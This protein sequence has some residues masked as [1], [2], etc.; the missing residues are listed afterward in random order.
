M[1]A[2]PILRTESAVEFAYVG[3]QDHTYRIP[4]G[5]ELEP[6]RYRVYSRWLR[7]GADDPPA[8]TVAP[9]TSSPTP[10][11]TGTVS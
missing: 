11:S 2:S 1:S 3:D 5:L 8:F 6:G 10:T 9:I 7:A 4:E